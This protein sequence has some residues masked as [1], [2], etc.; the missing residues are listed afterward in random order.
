MLLTIYI[1]AIP[2]LAIQHLGL[3]HA[4]LALAS[5]QLAKLRDSP[6]TAALKHYH[7]AIRRVASSVKSPSKRTQPA[8]LAATLLLGYFEVWSSDHTKWCNHLFGARILFREMSLGEMTR[9]CFPV[10][11]LR[12]GQEASG[13]Q[14]GHI[15]SQFYGSHQQSGSAQ[16]E[17]INLDYDFLRTIT[18]LKVTPED[19]GEGETLLI[20][21]MNA[22]AT[23][24]E[25][26]KYDIICD[27]FWWY[28]KMDVYQS[29]L[30]GTKLL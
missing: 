11:R 27:L 1:D 21:R 13:Y 17:L 18:G 30:G 28:C 5:L 22:P 8:T 3:F 7:R 12:Q 23:D 25:I 9:S 14:L 15:S 26:E 19:Y 4:M 16:G 20:D 10:K 29:I 6:P 2:T 24:K